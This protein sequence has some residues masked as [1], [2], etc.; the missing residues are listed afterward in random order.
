MVY[1]ADTV[2]ARNGLMNTKIGGAYCKLAW[3]PGKGVKGP[4]YKSYWSAEDGAS[5]IPWDLVK[6][7]KLDQLAVGGVID[8]DTYP[9]GVKHLPPPK[10]KGN[11][12]LIL[13][14][15]VMLFCVDE[16]ST[17]PPLPQD[18]DSM[19][20]APPT[21]SIVAPPTQQPPPIAPQM[22]TSMPPPTIPQVQTFQ[23]PPICMPPPPGAPMNMMPP[24]AGPYGA[25]PPPG[26][27]QG[28]PPPIGAPPPNLRP[29]FSQPVSSYS[30]YH[31]VHCTTAVR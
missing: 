30:A 28:P 9:P 29:P 3:A 6:Q 8:P 18:T 2:R 13:P 17:A 27:M 24:P 10:P 23:P 21:T 25:T 7:D 15:A 14:R 16:M 22:M 5:F 26:H 12:H 1:R 31:T 4:D 19:G 11:G 20:T